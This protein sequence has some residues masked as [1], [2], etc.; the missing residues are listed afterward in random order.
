VPV[1]VRVEEPRSGAA[2]TLVSPA[3]YRI[4]G[5]AV[6]DALQALRELG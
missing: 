4:E 5:L 3:G 2:V 6:C 1:E